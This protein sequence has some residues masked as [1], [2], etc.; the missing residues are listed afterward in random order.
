MFVPGS[1]AAPLV[2]AGQ[3]L[4]ELFVYISRVMYFVPTVTHCHMFFV[5]LF[6]LSAVHVIVA[7]LAVVRAVWQEAC[8]CPLSECW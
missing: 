7:V 6:A 1:N 2:G 5:C 8:V 4:V 3:A